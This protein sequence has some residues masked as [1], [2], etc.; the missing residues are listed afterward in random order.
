MKTVTGLGPFVSAGTGNACAVFDKINVDPDRD[1]DIIIYTYIFLSCLFN[2]YYLCML[3]L[4]TPYGSV[5]LAPI[6]CAT[7]HIS[8]S[9]SRSQGSSTRRLGASAREENVVENREKIARKL[10]ENSQLSSIVGNEALG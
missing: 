10:R 5:V 6:H 2:Y 3:Y 9:V 4:N 8:H 1:R 7:G